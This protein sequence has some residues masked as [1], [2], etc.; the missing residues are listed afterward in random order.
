MSL[1]LRLG[2]DSTYAPNILP[3]MIIMSLGMGLIFVPLSAT[4][5]FGVGNHDAGVAS[6]VLNTSQQIG[7]TVGV[8]FLNTIAASATTSF[9]IAN[10]LQ[11]PNPEALVEGF[12]AAFAWSVGI[13]AFA[14]LIWVVLVRMTKNDMASNDAV[15]AVT[16]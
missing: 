3:S 4:A 2:A 15:P 12:T 8:A 16:H 14:G 11:G 1:Y 6:A 10:N 5:L 9:I 7:G 13:M